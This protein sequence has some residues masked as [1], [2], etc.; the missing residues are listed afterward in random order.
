MASCEATDNSNFD[1]LNEDIRRLLAY[2]EAKKELMDAHMVEYFTSNH[3]E[4]LLS[5]QL[6]EDLESLTHEQLIHL[7]TVAYDNTSEEYRTLGEHL[8]TFLEKA[9]QAQLKSFTWVKDQKE[10]TSENKVNFISHIMTPKKSYEV[11]VMSDVVGRLAKRFQVNK[12]LDLGS[13]KGYLSQCL[14]LQYGLKV[15]G[16]DSSDGN[17]QNAARRNERLLKVWTGLVKKSKREKDNSLRSGTMLVFT[18]NSK[19]NFEDSSSDACTSCCDGT[20]HLCDH[21]GKDNNKQKC[22]C[23][24]SLLSST[25]PE[26][27][28]FDTVHRCLNTEISMTVKSEQSCM[29]AQNPTSYV[30]VTGLVDQSFVSNGT[31]T[32]LF[33]ELGSPSDVENMECDGMFIVGLHTCGDL[34]PTALRIFTSQSSVKLICIVGC[35]YHLVTQDLEGSIDSDNALGF[36]MSQFLKPFQLQIS[37]NATMVAQQAADRISSESQ[38]PPLSVLYRAILQVILKEKFGLDGSGMR[39]GKAGAKCKDFKEYVDKCLNKLGLK[40]RMSEL[41]EEEVNSYLTR[42]KHHERHL[43]AFHQQHDSSTEGRKKC[44]AL[45]T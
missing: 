15:V 29:Y 32:R 6:R 45:T 5:P 35:C 30:P 13:G 14:A 4:S 31:L 17:T 24:S 39:V 34:A 8:K 18:H 36:P 2:L 42:F 41:S 23:K 26:K 16:V 7:P 3:W 1:H 40:E 20:L 9:R 19:E 12:I 43:H 33:D 25:S 28:S 37:R 11:D 10:F 21:C 22:F 27:G 38:C 44:L